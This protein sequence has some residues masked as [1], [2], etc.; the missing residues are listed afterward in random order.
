MIPESWCL[1]PVI[2][3]RKLLGVLAEMPAGAASIDD[4]EA[5]RAG[6]M[7]IVF[8]APSTLDTLLREFSF[9]HARH[10]ESVLREHM[11]A[12]AGR[13]ELLA[14]TQRQAYIDID[15]DS[16]RPTYRHTKQGASYG[17]TKIAG[18]QVLRK[19]PSRLATTISTPGCVSVIAGIRATGR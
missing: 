12:L 6:G 10:L 1:G 8:Y 15:I 17:H 13:T 19:G 11:V 18:K 7:P 9:G 16:L 4:L 5:L 14:G 3:R 2:L